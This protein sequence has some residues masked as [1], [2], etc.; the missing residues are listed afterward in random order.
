MHTLL[1]GWSIARWLRL[2][3]GL[4]IGVLS[5][6]M[7]DELGGFIAALFLFQAVANIGCCSVKNYP[8]QKSRKD[9]DEEVEFEEVKS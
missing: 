2:A 8:E 4:I 3:A 7:Q 1:S 9:K 5:I 6:R